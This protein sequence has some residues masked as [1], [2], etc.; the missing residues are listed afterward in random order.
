MS[1]ENKFD[2]LTLEESLF[3]SKS[4]AELVNAFFLKGDS[5]GAVLSEL[6]VRA[7]K[8]D[9]AALGG[10][11]LAL[12]SPHEDLRQPAAK[13]L[14]IAGERA[15]EKILSLEIL[16][17]VEGDGVYKREA[18][19]E[20]LYEI[21]RNHFGKFVEKLISLAS[22]GR[23]SNKLTA[24]IDASKKLALTAGEETAREAL[25]AL[26][27]VSECHPDDFIRGIVSVMLEEIA[28]GRKEFEEEVKSYFKARAEREAKDAEEKEKILENAM[29][30]VQIARIPLKKAAVPPD[31]RAAGGSNIVPIERAHSKKAGR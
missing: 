29:N 25:L 12:Q 2:E 15:L 10:L 20:A 8:G 23:V 30:G 24:M 13:A 6:A 11:L 26:A 22:E 19:V 5:W 1:E 18:G 31:G 3:A 21:G 27:I 4:T 16:D 28:R 7:G 9:N 17:C 14:G